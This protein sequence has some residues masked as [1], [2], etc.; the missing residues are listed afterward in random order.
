MATSSDIIYLRDFK[1]WAQIGELAWE[2]RIK[3]PILLN[4]ELTTDI[5]ASAKSADL[6]HTVD[7]AVLVQRLEGFVTQ[8]AFVLLEEVAEEVANL[9]L[10]EF[11]VSKVRLQVAKPE[12]FPSVK[13]AGI[14]I[15][16]CSVSDVH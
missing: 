7:Y 14:I 6:T 3:Q 13:E 9:I 15:E 16:R 2:Q 4:I 10:Q 5:R 1:L 12:V 8:K 11:K